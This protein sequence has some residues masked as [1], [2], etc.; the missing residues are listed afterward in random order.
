MYRKINRFDCEGKTSKCW[1]I[2]AICAL[3][4]SGGR[5]VSVRFLFPWYSPSVPMEHHS[6]CFALSS[7]G[8]SEQSYKLRLSYHIHREGTKYPH[9]DELCRRL[10]QQAE[11]FCDFGFSV[12]DE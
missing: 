1:S 9:T 10:F 12:K 5:L 3:V 8:Y 11:L 2:P 6:F 4:S 7:S